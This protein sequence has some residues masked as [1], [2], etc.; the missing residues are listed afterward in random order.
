M[1]PMVALALSAL[2]A[3]LLTFALPPHDLSFLSFI[4]LVP[5]FY[6]LDNSSISFAGLCGW[7]F[8]ILT[9]IGLYFWVTK[10]ESLSVP[11]FLLVLVPVYAIYFAAFSVTVKAVGSRARLVLLF[12][13][14]ALWTLLEL[15]RA[16]MGFLALPWNLMG[17]SMHTTPVLIQISDITGVYGISFILVMVNRYLADILN[18]VMTGVPNGTRES[19][20]L[21]FRKAVVR[22]PTGVMA[23]LLCLWVGYGIYGLNTPSP[24]KSFRVAVIQGN[25]L[26]KSGMSLIEQREHLNS[27]KIL[28][29]QALSR[30]PDLVIWPASTLPA[31]LESSRLVKIFMNRL[32]R[33]VRVPIL[34]GGAGYDKLSPKKEGM[35]PFSNTEFLLSAEGKIEARYNKIRLLPFNEYPPLRGLVRWPRYITTIE[36]GFQPGDEYTIFEVGD[37]RFSTPIC[38]ENNFPRMV[39]RFVREGANLL[40]SVT[41]EGFMGRT[42]GPYQT[43]AMSVFRAVEN[44]TSVVR[45]APTGITAII[46]PAGRIVDRVR[47]EGGN[48]LFVPGFLVGDV[49][50]KEKMTFYSLYGDV[51]AFS[52]VG[53]FLILLVVPFIYRC[54]GKKL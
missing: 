27:Y 5:L 21:R 51:F 41:N 42:A 23:A 14:P 11:V 12:A 7:L 22:W 46:D 31:P 4:A 48:D 36:E 20:G 49:P 10:I 16:N 34:V 39:R 8:G 32:A 19:A 25:S 1:R 40:I 18:E 3:V 43:L 50:L 26:A 2:S 6:A 33:E 13:W 30:E 29:I 28:T 54:W 37:A 47:D 45:S 53:I 24:P 44:R 15:I 38:W 35:R 52:C 17:H 9:G